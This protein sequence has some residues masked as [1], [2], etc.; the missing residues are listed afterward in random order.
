MDNKYIAQEG[1]CFKVKD[2]E[3]GYLG[4]ILYLG[5]GDSIDNYE[6]VDISE[7]EAYEAEQEKKQKEEEL[8]RLMLELYPPEE[9][10][11]ANED[12]E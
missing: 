7:R 5:K 9:E 8:R 6:E 10:V 3:D 11:A 4:S 12:T 1:K 2:V